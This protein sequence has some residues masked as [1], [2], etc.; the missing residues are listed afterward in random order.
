MKDSG[1]AVKE[2][3]ISSFE[4]V[5]IGKSRDRDIAQM[6]NKKID[7][8]LMAAKSS[9]IKIFSNQQFWNYKT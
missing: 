2:G 6:K 8:K 1:N 5:Y 9:R 7:L 3:I 4:Q